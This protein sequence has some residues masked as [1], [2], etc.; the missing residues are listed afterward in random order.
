MDLFR[1]IH[2]PQTECDLSQKERAAL[3]ETHS[4]ECGPSQKAREHQGMG[5]SVSIG[6]GNFI[7]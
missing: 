1:E 4:T 2:I 7:G 5:L 6:V 3:G